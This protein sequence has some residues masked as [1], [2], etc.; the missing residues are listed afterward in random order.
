[1]KLQQLF[2]DFIHRLSPRNQ[3]QANYLE[4]DVTGL[5]FDTQKVI[6]D[7]VFFAIPGI[8]S[9]GHQYIPQAVEKG[10]IALV[11]ENEMNVPESFSGM[12]YIVPSTREA[13]DLLSARFYEYPS[14]KLF[15]IGV[16][17]TNGK[18]SITYILEHILNH[19][20]KLTGVMGTVN[21]RVGDRVWDSQMTT[22]D[23]V[24]LQSR[25]NDFVE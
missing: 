9:D 2:S 3:M 7:S 23:P 4:S 17:G 11:V 24:T 25:L 13:L 10:A 12:V 8:K 19:N 21:H 18:T 14:D 1:M 6:K 15:C 16:T 5:F 20:K 22:P